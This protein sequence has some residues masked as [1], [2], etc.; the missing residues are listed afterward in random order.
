MLELTTLKQT[1]LDYLLSN[2]EVSP[3][4]C[5]LFEVVGATCFDNNEWM[6][7]ISIVGLIGKYWSVFVDGNTGKIS[8][9]WE[10][11]T[12]CEY[13]NEPHQYS[14]LPDY[15]NQLLD[16]LTVKILR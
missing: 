12:D 16:R 9:D 4:H 7:N 6:I 3:E 15:L 11:N 14:H 10:F 8:P 2:L 13:L 5:H 1:A